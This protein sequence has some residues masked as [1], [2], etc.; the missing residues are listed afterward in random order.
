VIALAAYRDLDDAVAQANDHDYG[1]AGFVF[2]RD[3]EE[4]RGVGRRIRAGLVK[5]NRIDPSL[6]SPSGTA[7]MWG[8]S[9]HGE[10][11]GTKGIEFFTGARCVG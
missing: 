10:I 8:Q 11:G 5:I 1:L 7:S 6:P 3:R 2:G 4:A 9:G